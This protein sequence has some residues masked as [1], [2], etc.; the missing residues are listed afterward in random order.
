MALPNTTNNSPSAGYIAW[1]A[2]TIQYQGQSFAIA[3][4]NTNQ[5]WVWWRYNGGGS[6]SIIEA[7][8]NVPTNLADDD[9]VLL[10]N[11]NGIAVRIQT[12]SYVDGELLVDG[13]VIAAALAAD[14]IDGKVITGAFIQTTNVANRGIKFDS[15]GLR[16]WSNTGENTLAINASTGSVSF[17]GT[18]SS[19]STIVG[20]TIM[21]SMFTT[22]S[23]QFPDSPYVIVDSN[24]VSADGGT[25]GRGFSLQASGKTFFRDDMQIHGDVLI[26]PIYG[27]TANLKIKNGTLTVEGK[28]FLNGSFELK[29]DSINYMLS[30]GKLYSLAQ[31]KNTAGVYSAMDNGTLVVGTWINHFI[32]TGA[33]VGPPDIRVTSTEILMRESASSTTKYSA[34]GISNSDTDALIEVKTPGNGTVRLAANSGNA[35]VS[36]ATGQVNITTTNGTI[37]INPSGSNGYLAITP[38]RNFNIAMAASSSFFFITGIGN[39]NAT[40]L[41]V[42]G[43]GLVTKATSSRKYK[44]NFEDVSYSEL[45]LD[46]EL[47][48]FQYK[49]EIRN[50]EDNPVEMML[51]RHQLGVIAEDVEELGL[52]DVMVYDQAGLP[53][54]VNYDRFGLLLVPIVKKQRQQIAELTDRINALEGVA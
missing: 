47:Q 13:S 24:G 3:A 15:T 53:D 18:I 39:A 43:N 50:Y 49:D 21:G 44:T 17:K 34:T 35:N 54:S 40:A 11:R 19:G 45:V 36:S 22:Y 1:Q 2:F 38:T 10:G 4:G 6:N 16:A 8:P 5:R 37:N 41:H 12:T 25:V 26:D 51:P 33:S 42:A 30:G 23:S 27:G 20:S 9:L 32:T 48:R 29:E 7:G 46:V 31:G 52:K 14:A 28:T